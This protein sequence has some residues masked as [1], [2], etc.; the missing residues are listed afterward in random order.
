MPFSVSAWT[1]SWATAA[2]KSLRLSPVTMVCWAHRKYFDWLGARA[3]M[4][5]AEAHDRVRIEGRLPLPAEHR[6]DDGVGLGHGGV[7]GERQALQFFQPHELHGG[8]R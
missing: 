8:R 7:V 2:C 1:C 4:S 6:P 3:L 5:S